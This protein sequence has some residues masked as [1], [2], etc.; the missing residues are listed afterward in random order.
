MTFAEAVF[1]GIIQGATEFLPVSSSGHLVIAEYFMDL[2]E[3]SIDFDVILHL[4]TLM[5]VLSYFWRDWLAM[6]ASVL[7]GKMSDRKKQSRRMLLF[8][9]AGTIPGAVAGFLVEDLVSTVFRSPWVVV[10]TLAGVALLLWL[11]ER[12]ARYSRN[13]NQMILKDAVA[14]GTAQ[15]AALI[16]GVSRSGITMTAALFLGLKREAAARFSFLL[17]API[18]AGAGVYQG[19]KLAQT[20]FACVSVAYLWGFLAAG[21][22]G[23]IAIA[24][25]MRYLINH[26]F[27]PFVYYRLIIAFIVAVVLKVG[28]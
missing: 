19:L 22:S 25:L 5:A 6:A 28:G 1:L 14:I 24:F 17:S 12:T 26:T 27:Y 20:G 8:V 23:Y 9:L 10:S 11:A 2:G 7:S 15:A 13:S 21:I 4:G 3:V 18:I 16:P